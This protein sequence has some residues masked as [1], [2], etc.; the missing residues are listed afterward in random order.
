MVQY[1]I[2][3]LLL[4]I[5]TVLVISIIS[6]IIIQLPP[7]DFLT[8]YIATLE[9]GGQIVD[10]AQIDALRQQYGLGDPVY[11]QYFKWLSGVLQGNFGQSLQWQRPVAELIGER[12]VLTMVLSLSALLLVWAIALPVGIYS[13]VKQYSA[14]DFFFTFLSFVGLGI[15]N[16]LIALVLMWVAYTYFG[17]SAGGLF[18]PQYADAAWSWAKFVD[19]LAHLWIPAVVLAF[20]G[21]AGLVRIMRANLLDELPKQYVVTA[22]AK[23]MTERGLV[24]KYPV[25]VALNPFV[26]TIGWTLPGLVSGSII[27]SVVLNLP[28][29][30]PM[31][32]TSLQS[33]D[34]YLAGAI[35]LL[36]ST[37]TVIGTLLSD[38][39]LAWLD[40]RIRFN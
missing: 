38:I 13:A 35:L 23:G 18:S 33:Q 24:W 16:F 2:Q 26:S 30:G 37:L 40:P 5:P 21:V 39:L 14:G 34:M 4:V 20:G 17:L 27:V 29:T 15:P 25:R 19:F 11:I 3:R 8:S 1:I 31:L 10:Q 36:L 28:T 9:S 32:L 7:G 12:M 6:F 22:R